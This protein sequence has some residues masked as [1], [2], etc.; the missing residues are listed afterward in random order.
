MAIMQPYVKKYDAQGNLTNPLEGKGYLHPVY[1]YVDEFKEIKIIP[2]PNHNA[3]KRANKPQKF[4]NRALTLG[5]MKSRVY[6]PLFNYFNHKHIP[7][8]A[9]EYKALEDSS[10]NCYKLFTGKFKITKNYN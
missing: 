6:H 9:K 5:R 1:S 10:G 4:N 8:T 7:I 2:Y 3:R